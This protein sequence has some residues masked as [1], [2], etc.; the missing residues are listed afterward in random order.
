MGTK[1]SPT[2]RGRLW[3]DDEMIRQPAA[4]LERAKKMIEPPQSFQA[5]FAAAQSLAGMLPDSGWA[6]AIEMATEMAQ[7]HKRLIAGLELE[8]EFLPK[9][10]QHGRAP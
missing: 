9:L 2:E 1:K 7:S 8:R 5:A 4:D 10:A 6:W 3:M